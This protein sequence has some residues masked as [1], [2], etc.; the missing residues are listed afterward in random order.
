MLLLQ[1]LLEYV[2]ASLRYLAEATL[3][4]AACPHVC[5]E[6]SAVMMLRISCAGHH[7]AAGGHLERLAGCGCAAA[8]LPGQQDTEPGEPPMPCSSYWDLTLAISV[9]AAN[10]HEV[11]CV[12]IWTVPCQWQG[13]PVTHTSGRVAQL[14]WGRQPNLQTAG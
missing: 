8:P 11:A 5:N 13:R 1:L 4:L 6:M 3:E 12:A 9:T 10:A 7:T 2:S 14:L